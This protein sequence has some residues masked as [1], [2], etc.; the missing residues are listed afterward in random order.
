MKQSYQTQVSK[1]D[2]MD[3]PIDLSTY[4][5]AKLFYLNNFQFNI[6]KSSKFKAKT[7]QKDKKL[8]SDDAL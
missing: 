7:S 3:Y 4:Q 2:K 6:C 5:Q 1:K 8:S